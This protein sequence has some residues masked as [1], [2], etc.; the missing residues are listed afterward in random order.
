MDQALLFL[1]IRP[2]FTLQTFPKVENLA[3]VLRIALAVKASALL[4]NCQYLR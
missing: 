2:W 1:P 4:K 3:T